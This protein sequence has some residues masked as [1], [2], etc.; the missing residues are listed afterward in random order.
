MKRGSMTSKIPDEV[1]NELSEDLFMRKC[2]LENLGGCAGSIQWHHAF[3]YAGKRRNDI[4][5][6][7]PVCEYH[8]RV[9]SAFRSALKQ[10]LLARAKWFGTDIKRK[11]PKTFL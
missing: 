1:R 11:Y 9:E 8:H 7:L 5:A 3:S 10:V 6:I 2:C 4:W